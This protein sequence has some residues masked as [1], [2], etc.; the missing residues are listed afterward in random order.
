M[1]IYKKKK[2]F[3]LPQNRGKR[4]KIAE[5]RAFLGGKL[6]EIFAPIFFQKTQKRAQARVI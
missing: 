1:Y 5:I 6:G 2:F 4:G 3:K